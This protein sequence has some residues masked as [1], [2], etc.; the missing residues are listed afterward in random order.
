MVFENFR[1]IKTELDADT[2]AEME[3]DTPNATS[4]PDLVRKNLNSTQE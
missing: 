2:D 1:K 3:E 4:T